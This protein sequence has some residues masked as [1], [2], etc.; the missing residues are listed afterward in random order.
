MN[1]LKKLKQYTDY[2]ETE[3]IIVD[4]ILKNP[5]IVLKSTAKELAKAT[6][7]SASTIVRLSQKLGFSG[8][9]DFQIQFANDSQMSI[10]TY[11]IDANYPF[12]A[13]DDLNTIIQKMSKLQLEAIN[14]TL[15]L[16]EL[17]QYEKA[18]EMLSQAEVIDIYG[19]GINIHM[20]ADFN[21]KLRR[22][23]RRVEMPL[24]DLD[25]LFNAARST[26][27]H[28]ALIIS[29]TG[30]NDTVLKYAEILKQSNTP[31][32]SITSMRNNSLSKYSDVS[33][34]V[35]SK[36]N[37][38]SKIGTFSSRISILMILDFIYAGIFG[39]DYEENKDYST[40]IARVTSFYNAPYTKLDEDN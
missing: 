6:H 25:Q 1:V 9:H 2:S 33:L 30:E 14:E 8:Y 4:F 36:E 11:D 24:N 40:R 21:Y 34:N 29:Y 19:T 3:Q 13:G 12:N 38:Y 20:A 16:V 23:N 32:V 17:D 26:D 7:S 10:P 39:K 28:C 18:I 27:T 37:V 22:I 31:I 15:L 35:V 5:D